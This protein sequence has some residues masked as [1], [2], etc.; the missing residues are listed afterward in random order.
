MKHKL[1]DN[2]ILIII[3]GIVLIICFVILSLS[4][5]GMIKNNVV[6]G[7]T[8]ICFIAL[9][10][11]MTIWVLKQ[12]IG[13]PKASGFIIISITMFLYILVMLGVAAKYTAII[14]FPDDKEMVGIFGNVIS[15]M[16]SAGIG[17]LGA[18]IG[19]KYTYKNE[20]EKQ[21][22]VDEKN[23]IMAVNIITKLLWPEI[24]YNCSQLA[25]LKDCLNDDFFKKPTV[26]VYIDGSKI[27]FYD[28]NT[29]KFELIKY[30]S[31]IVEN[32]I[33]LYNKLLFLS[34]ISKLNDL[35]LEEFNSIKSI[36]EIKH[37]IGQYIANN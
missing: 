36:F 30:N 32:T 21:K 9:F 35:T 26:E 22:L 3:L 24:T 31:E 7:L 8:S 12:I 6:I 28:Y 19:V 18:I 13:N 37:S 16:I 20:A 4:T 10:I 14:F 25:N 11:I 23:K 27:K 29:I 5:R 34:T 15:A 1:L 2:S 33:E 17:I